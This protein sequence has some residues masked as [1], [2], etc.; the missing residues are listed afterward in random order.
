MNRD[1]HW[2]VTNRTALLEL[3]AHAHP[4]TYHNAEIRIADRTISASFGQ[5]AQNWLEALHFEDG[6]TLKEIPYGSG[7]IFWVA[8]PVEL[9]EDLRS[10]SDLYSYIASRIGIV[11]TFTSNSPLRAGTLIFPTELADSILYVMVSDSAEDADI[12][13]QDANTGITLAF[14]LPHEHA[15]IAL[16]DKKQKKIIGRY[17]F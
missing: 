8:Y 3:T 12:N 7:R 4:V 9:A 1:E 17:G 11:S 13:I 16:I 15:A 6:S 5:Q 14:S 2:Q 10:S